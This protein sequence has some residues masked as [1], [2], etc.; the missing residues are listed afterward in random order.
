MLVELKPNR[1]L[2]TI[3]LIINV[4]GYDYENN[5]N[6]M[7]PLRIDFRNKTA[8]LILKNEIFSDIVA[9][10]KKIPLSSD[11]YVC[12]ANFIMMPKLARNSNKDKT[13]KL[14]SVHLKKLLEQ[15]NKIIKS[16]IINQ[17][18][19]KYCRTLSNIPNYSKSNFSS[20][21]C[22]MLDFFI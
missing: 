12:L 17:L 4:A 8:N 13:D 22:P 15:F 2:F 19:N 3:F 11:D 10:I 6:G 18:F 14:V 16:P 5:P 1:K 20:H 7:H 21:L 9:T